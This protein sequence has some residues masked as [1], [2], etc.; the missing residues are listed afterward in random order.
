[1][2]SVKNLEK[3]LAHCYQLASDQQADQ[4]LVLYEQIIID[5]P[6]CSEAHIGRLQC[7]YQLKQFD[8][9]KV[10][11]SLQAVSSMPLPDD[12]AQWRDRLLGQ[13]SEP[14]SSPRQKHIA[15][16]YKNRANRYQLTNTPTALAS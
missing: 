12:L 9:A 4:A 2:Q 15:L 1:M 7:L 14:H 5:Y 3:A 10:R 6:Y 8:E 13:M 11:Q 16:T